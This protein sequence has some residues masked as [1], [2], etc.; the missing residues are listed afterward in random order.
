MRGKVAECCIM[1]SFIICIIYQ[2]LL[3]EISVPHGGECEDDLRVVAQCSL[4]KITGVSQALAASI[5]RMK[6]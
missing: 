2:R 5:I 4:V 1:R 3:V 6:S